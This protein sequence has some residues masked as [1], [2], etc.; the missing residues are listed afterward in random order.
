[1]KKIL[2]T[3][4]VAISVFA[5]DAQS[6]KHSG[7]SKKTVSKE[8][9]ATAAF[10]KKEAEKKMLRDSAIITMRMDD[11]LRVQNDSLA[12]VQKQAES[13][14]YL[15]N[16]MKQTDSMN[17]E[18]YTA[19]AAERL[20]QDKNEKEAIDLAKSAKLND[21]QLRQVKLI[22]ETYAVKVKEVSAN[23]TLDETQKQQQITTLNTERMAK[24][25]TVAGKNKAKKIERQVKAANESAMVTK[26]AV[27]Q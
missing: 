2:L 17:K 13:V 24:I 21:Y 27:K 20:A 7:R 22:N 1:M 18:K 10:A 12:D 5:A 19:I 3:C 8:A 14:A 6:K 4:L 11:S 15:E 25:K 9:R 16:G 23:T 26:P